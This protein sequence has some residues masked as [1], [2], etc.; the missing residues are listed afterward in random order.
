MEIPVSIV[1]QKMGGIMSIS[2]RMGW[3]AGC[4]ALLL[5]AGAAQAEPIDYIFTGTGTGTLNGVAFSG[6]FT[7]TDIAD[8][9]GITS[10]GG[11]YRNTP[12]SSTFSSSAGTASMLDPIVIENTTPPGFMGFGEVLAPFPDESLTNAVFET[13]A[14]NTALSSTSGGLSVAPAT[15]TTSVGALD[16][17]TI[18]ALSFEATVASVP[19]PSSVVLLT[20]VL[21][22]FGAIGRRV[23]RT[24][25]GH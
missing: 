21:L 2:L 22:A 13:Y 14:L 9:S 5:V 23:Y 12:T 3:L 11:E 6:T 16:F 18:T 20:T 24:R 15:F 10:G 17:T 4:A 7:V 19:E 8:T 25:L 1:G